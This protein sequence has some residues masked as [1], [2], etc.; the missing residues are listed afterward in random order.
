M[1]S[2]WLYEGRD[3]I[4]VMM[5]D[6]R[7]SVATRGRCMRLSGHLLMRR[8]ES[9]FVTTNEDSESIQSLQDQDWR[10]LLKAVEVKLT[11]IHNISYFAPAFNGFYWKILAQI[12][13]DNLYKQASIA[14]LFNIARSYVCKTL[15]NSASRSRQNWHWIESGEAI[16]VRA[17]NSNHTTPPT[18]YTKY[19]LIF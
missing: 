2:L 13:I 3:Q 1:S 15:L 5:P 14:S 4:R 11:K 19:Q 12:L 17:D 16:I 9:T 18:N 6:T 7:P 8:W 10:F